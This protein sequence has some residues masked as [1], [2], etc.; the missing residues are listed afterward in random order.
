[1]NDGVRIADK[2]KRIKELVLKG[3]EYL[4]QQN[5]NEALSTFDKV[6]AEEPRFFGAIIGKMK[7]FREQY[8][9]EN[10]IKCCDKI[11]EINPK[12][13]TAIEHKIWSLYAL[14]RIDEA[15]NLARQ[16][17]KIY[18]DSS[19]IQ[20]CIDATLEKKQRMG[21]TVIDKE[22]KV[23]I[24]PPVIDKERKREI[25]PPSDTSEMKKTN[26]FLIGI[27]YSYLMV[28]IIVFL[29]ID[30]LYFR[31]LHYNTR[32]FIQIGL[33]G[34]LLISF[35]IL[36]YFDKH[37]NL[38]E[39]GISTHN[40]NNSILIGILVSSGFIITALL[41][42]VGPI[43]D[44]FSTILQIGFLTI[45]IG[46][47]EELFFRGYIESKARKSTR[48]MIAILITGILFA[49]LHVP[50]YLISPFIL[51][52]ITYLS[53]VPSI[54]QQLIF[55]GLLFG[56]IR[57]NTKN[58]LGP[59][60]AHSTWDFYLLIYMPT[61]TYQLY[62]MPR[63]GYFMIFQ[64]AASGAMI[65]TFILAWYLSSISK[66]NILED[67]REFPMIVEEFNSKAEKYQ[68]KIVKLQYKINYLSRRQNHYRQYNYMAYR[69]LERKK[70]ILE[71]KIDFLN[72]NKE[73]FLKLAENITLD[74]Y[75]EIMD[76]KDEQLKTVKK[77]LILSIKE[78]KIIPY[79]TVSDRVKRPGFNKFG[80]NIMTINSRIR[81][82]ERKKHPIKEKIQL[83]TMKQESIQHKNPRAVRQ[84]GLKKEK[85]TCQMEY[86]DTLINV[87]KD[88]A[89][90]ITNSN[91]KE[92]RIH[93]N[94]QKR[95]AKRRLNEK[96]RT[97]DL[98][99]YRR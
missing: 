49:A 36:I 20:Q 1:M 83:Y 51:R 33:Y 60:I 79:D 26:K 44:D 87:Y 4:K 28:T 99:Y 23:E 37:T 84:L 81:E 14:D 54:V 86:Y 50:K 72:R 43:I 2:I 59:I 52:D 64:M 19:S 17:Q 6:I 77:D 35:L 10:V 96:L 66:V 98:Q 56:F 24:R 58:I 45:L 13:I 71:N 93:L 41:F 94:E 5:Y 48:N 70:R 16:A 11:L 7:V 82:L 74:N 15:L 63:A 76:N 90:T 67:P 61:T 85:L 89:E 18:P 80:Y 88:I 12:E 68:K 21:E 9:W 95:I 73:E 34:C 55:L 22:R 78:S 47:V 8:Q 62:S 75:T 39:L 25:R 97:V 65:G 31:N 38:K 42:W 30:L 57:E 53:S 69:S 3:N 27:V 32:L 29:I 40:L 91:F 92:K 46:M